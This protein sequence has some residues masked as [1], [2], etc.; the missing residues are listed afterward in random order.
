M[1]DKD[2]FGGHGVNDAIG[3]SIKRMA[4]LVDPVAWESLQQQRYRFCLMQSQT[5][6]LGIA[7]GVGT[8]HAV[9]SATAGAAAGAL[10]TAYRA[11][12]ADAATACPTWFPDRA[13][14]R[15]SYVNLT[16]VSPSST[17]VVV[18]PQPLS[19][20]TTSQLKLGRTSMDCHGC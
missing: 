5:T 15:L 13:L 12:T 4:R 16:V 18:S 10:G 6:R 3:V 19:L 1:E 9:S 7:F 17:V 20:S 8:R 11:P 14:I 2:C